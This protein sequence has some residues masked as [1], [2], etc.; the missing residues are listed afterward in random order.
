[1]SSLT[2]ESRVF[3]EATI[4]AT[5]VGADSLLRA[6]PGR[7]I[8]YVSDAGDRNILAERDAGRARAA[9]SGKDIGSKTDRQIDKHAYRQ[10]ARTH[11]I[12]SQPSR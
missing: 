3:C 4:G 7:H 5:D 9:E 11:A 6:C 1:V 8:V 10:C 2:I 12:V